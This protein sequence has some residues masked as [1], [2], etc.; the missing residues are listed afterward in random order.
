M[1]INV[2]PGDDIQTF[3]PFE[4]DEYNVL[5]DPKLIQTNLTELDVENVSWT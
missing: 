1:K 5:D 3:Y 4:K 2:C